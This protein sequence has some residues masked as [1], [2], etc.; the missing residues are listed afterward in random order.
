[1]CD[2]LVIDKCEISMWVVKFSIRKE[3]KCLLWGV[4]ILS[5]SIGMDI[6]IWGW[7]TMWDLQK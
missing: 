4:R 2:M 7:Y 6:S 5:E 3:S 1:M